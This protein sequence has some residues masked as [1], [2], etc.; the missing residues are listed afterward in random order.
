ME[1]ISAIQIE[2]EEG[3]HIVALSSI[4]SI[5]KRLAYYNYDSGK[6]GFHY[7][8]PL[9]VLKTATS[10]FYITENT[11]N[12]LKDSVFNISVKDKRTTPIPGIKFDT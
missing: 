1:I 6:Y 12:Y 2:D 5:E 7:L 3:T 10:K 11:Y 4:I 8:S 9:Y